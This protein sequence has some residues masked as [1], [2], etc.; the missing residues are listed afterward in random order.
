MHMTT[1][2][3]VLIDLSCYCYIGR[4]DKLAEYIMT[5]AYAI[6]L[7]TQLHCFLGCTGKEWYSQYLHWQFILC[8]V[9]V[10]WQRI[11]SELSELH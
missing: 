7:N 3:C 9:P 11:L 1:Y 5:T 4:N 2:H 10:A 8:I 6:A